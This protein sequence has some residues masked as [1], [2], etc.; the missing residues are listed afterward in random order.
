MRQIITLFAILIALPCFGQSFNG[1]IKKQSIVKVCDKVAEWQIA[2]FPEV[3]YHELQWTDAV[4]YR[5]MVEWGK[6]TDNEKCISFLEEIGERN[7][8]HMYDRVYHAD[9]ICV[10]QTFI[11]MHKMNN[12]KVVLQPTLERAYYV[13]N[14]PSDAPL[15]KDDKRGKDER[16]S[17]C[18]ALFMA[19]PVYAELFTLTGEECY[20]NYL[21]SEFKTCTDSLYDKDAMLYYRDCKRIG[22]KEPNGAKQFWG[23]GNGWV[24]AA[25]SLVIE[26]LPEDY[27]NLSYYIELYKEM[28]QSVISTQDE[29]GMWHASLLDKES[30]PAPENSAAGLFCYGLAWGINNGYLTD[31]CYK[32]ALEKGWASLVSGVQSN[33]K[34]GYVQPVGAAPKSVDKDSSDVYGVGAFLLAGSELLKMVNKL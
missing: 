2:T 13:A 21:D 33:G 15:S 12:S 18:D 25:L 1:K 20:S 3:K 5:G 26:A 24:F 10:G 19:A 28:A 16:W 27:P 7:G 23:R 30:Y 17:W 14:H 11:Q 34:L 29:K 22:L 9:D 6:I 31:S 32:E 4:L 8:W